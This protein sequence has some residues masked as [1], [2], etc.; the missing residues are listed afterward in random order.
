MGTGRLRPDLHLRRREQEQP[1]V[2]LQ[3][4]QHLKVY[5]HQRTTDG[6]P[7]MSYQLLWLSFS[8][9]MVLATFWGY[10]RANKALEACR[11]ARTCSVLGTPERTSAFKKPCSQFHSSSTI[12]YLSQ[13]TILADDEILPGYEEDVSS[14]R[15]G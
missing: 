6:A 12:W 4:L 11:N 13:T 14:I 9:P 3:E 10:K 7:H 15:D 1:Q 5:K 8:T 2:T